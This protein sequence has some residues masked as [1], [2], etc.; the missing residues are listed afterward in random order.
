MPDSAD[1]F[2]L[3]TLA[4]AAKLV[5][6]ADAEAM[7]RLYRR[8]ILTCYKPGKALLTTAADV[9]Q[10]VMVKCRVGSAPRPK[11]VPN[12]LGLTEM[13]LSRLALERAREQLRE[14]RREEEWL[15]T[16][17][18]RKAARWPPRAR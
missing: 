2:T 12:E 7:K 5:P 18:A 10:A 13:D 6:G 9:R 15:R 8:G 11:A 14:Q 1:D 16:Y 3:L 17:E 4:E